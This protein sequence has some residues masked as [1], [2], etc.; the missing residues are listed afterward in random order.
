MP[1]KENSAP[2]SMEKTGNMTSQRWDEKLP[3]GKTRRE[4]ALR[5]LRESCTKGNPSRPQ[6]MDLRGISL[7]GESLA[8]L[9]LSGYDLTGADLSNAD[10]SEANLT[11]AKLRQARLYHARLYKC[12]LLGADLTEANLDGCVAEQAGFG[13]ATLEKASLIDAKLIRATFSEAQAEQ[14]DF[15]A[16][17]LSYATLRRTNLEGAN[18]SRAILFHADM[19]ESLVKKANFQMANLREARLMKIQNFRQANWIGADIRDMD[20]RGAYM[21]RRF[22]ADENYLFEFQ[23]RGKLHK[24]LYWIWWLTSDCGRSLFRWAVFLGLV[25]IGFAFLSMVAGIDYGPHKTRLSPLYYSVVTMTTLGYGD[26]VPTSATGQILA[27][28]EAVFGY[29]GL[30]GLLSILSNKIARRAD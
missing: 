24:F 14:A 6:E 17:D 27:M 15:R 26:A 29:V 7:A 13:V 21:I 20:L 9:N 22:I 19:K 28:I 3:N 30:G 18:F 1:I 4:E 10:L 5:I 12:E 8:G 2:I 25:V 16:A 23:T 11:W